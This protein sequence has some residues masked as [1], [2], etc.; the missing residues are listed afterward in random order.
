MEIM[1]PNKK[2]KSNSV[3]TEMMEFNHVLGKFKHHHSIKPDEMQAFAMK[4]WHIHSAYDQRMRQ[5]EQEKKFLE[6]SLKTMWTGIERI[7]YPVLQVDHQLLPVYKELVDIHIILDELKNAQ[8]FFA[9]PEFR[10][11]SLL[12]LQ[13]KLH[14]LESQKVN[15]VFM[16]PNVTSIQNQ[17]I[18]TGQALCVSLMNRCFNMIHYLQTLPDEYP[19]EPPS[20][21]QELNSSLVSILGCLKAGYD[22]DP[23]VLK[24]LKEQLTQIQNQRKDGVF[25]ELDGTRAV[26]QIRIQKEF[27]LAQDLLY[28]CLVHSPEQDFMTREMENRVYEARQQLWDQLEYSDESNDMSMLVY[29]TLMDPVTNAVDYCENLVS[30]ASHKLFSLIQSSLGTPSRLLH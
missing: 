7:L 30:S 16:P 3:G 12:L 1:S 21:L 24:L 6:R 14:K 27:D 25:Y 28:E 2:I 17:Q 22:F 26:D 4:A 5:I 19:T 18:P 15:G 9:N 20:K 10:N 11:A 23:M 8:S 13:E 29:H